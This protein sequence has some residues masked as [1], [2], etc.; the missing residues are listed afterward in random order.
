[1]KRE[2]EIQ[3]LLKKN[4]QKMQNE[5]FTCVPINIKANYPHYDDE[6]Q[7]LKSSRIF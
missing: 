1:L 5:Q 3:F 7:W 6:E 2:E 4:I